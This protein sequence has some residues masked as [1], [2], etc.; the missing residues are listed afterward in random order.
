MSLG[1]CK[2]TN[3]KRWLTRLQVDLLT[4]EA[5]LRGA[6]GLLRLIPKLEGL[7]SSYEELLGNGTARKAVLDDL[8]RCGKAGGLGDLEKLANVM[9]LNGAGGG[10]E[11]GR[12]G[13]REGE[14]KK[15]SP[16]RGR[17]YSRMR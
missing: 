15:C 7:L 4:D 12:D 3:Y 5:Q 8:N 6:P 2:A 14:R 9:L 13:R 16:T 17:G 10:W 11:R 1:P